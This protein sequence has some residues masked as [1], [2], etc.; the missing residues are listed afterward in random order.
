MTDPNH[1]LPEPLI[2]PPG[3][4]RFSLIWLVPLIAALVGLG[5]VVRTYLQAGPTIHVTFETAEGLETGK[6]EVRYKD[7]VIGK[8]Q[9]I[10]LTDDVSHVLVAIALEKSAARLAVADTQFWVVRPRIGVGGVSGINTLLSGAYIGVDAGQS[11]DARRDFIGLEKPP[12][13]THDRKGR[14]FTL[15][16]ADAGSI[17]IGAP[18]YFRR[19]PVGRVVD[20]EL[21]DDGHHVTLQVFIDA[22]Y[23]RFVSTNTRF[24]NAGGVDLALSSAGLKLNTQS[25]ATV[26]AGGIAFQP[27]DEDQPGPPADENSMFDLFSDQTTALTAPDGPSV[28]AVLVFPQSTR[29]LVAGTAVDFLGIRLGNVVS[30]EP[31]YDVPTKRFYTR[32]KL[33][34]FPERLGPA[35]R[36]LAAQQKGGDEMSSRILQ[37][38]IDQGLQAQ[39]RSG[40]LIT[41]QIYVALFFKPGATRHGNSIGADG[42]V[43]IPTTPGS[44][45][46]IQTQIESIVRKLN[47]IPFDEIGNKLSGTL[48]STQALIQQLNTE[49]APEARKLLQDAGQTIRALDQNLAAPDAPLQQDTRRTLEQINR[50]AASLR[51]LSDYLE[52]HPES[53]LRGKPISA[54]PKPD[55][56]K[57]PP[58]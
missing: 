41:G 12:A 16:A 43:E 7:V 18:L 55:S 53:L 15:R 44:L 47:N 9:S 32:V 19:V 23:D 6:T 10:A 52:Q 31:E 20:A 48:D 33:E 45:E 49:L 21:D 56:G 34:L 11:E 29:G 28:D 17:T 24:W 14:R 30:I 4:L 22:P 35:Y 38:F 8:V 54:E 3:G 36:T 42:I 13:I 50:A 26:L 37:R 2:K 1:A 39:L 40:N 27:L 5:L 46:E 25:L 51:T 58:P 57:A